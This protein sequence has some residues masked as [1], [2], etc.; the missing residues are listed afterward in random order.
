MMNLKSLYRYAVFNQLLVSVLFMGVTQAS[1]PA[2]GSGVS[3]TESGLCPQLSS[4]SIVIPSGFRAI[5]ERS[6]SNLTSP[7]VDY[8]FRPRLGTFR[9]VEEIQCK[10][11]LLGPAIQSRVLKPP[12]PAS[13]DI[14]ANEVGWESSGRVSLALKGQLELPPNSRICSY[15]YRIGSSLFELSP[16]YEREAF[17]FNKRLISTP[18]DCTYTGRANE[19]SYECTAR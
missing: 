6:L 8:Q 13:V 2:G 10:G 15:G 11:R 18:K 1:K 12:C 7:V 4:A 14:N 19:V 16:V 9:G 5:T 3:A 17:S